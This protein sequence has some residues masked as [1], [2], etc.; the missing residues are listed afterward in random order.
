[1]YYKT[2]QL[3]NKSIK[4]FGRRFGAGL[5]Y[6]KQAVFR[7]RERQLPIIL[8]QK[9]ERAKALLLYNEMTL[10]DCD[11]AKLVASRI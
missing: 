1:V 6:V 9:I 5:Q 11:S 3:K 8:L 2:E 7:R 4:L 10:S